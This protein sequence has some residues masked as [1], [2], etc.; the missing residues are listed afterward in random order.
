[1]VRRTHQQEG[2][3]PD[4]LGAALREGE[5]RDRSHQPVGGE[6]E[7]VA[8]VGERGDVAQAGVAVVVGLSEGREQLPQVDEVH[9]MDGQGARR[10]GSREGVRRRSSCFSKSSGAGRR[11]RVTYV[12]VRWRAPC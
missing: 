1:M 4:E 2:H 6:R 7:Q 10:E 3:G 8:R 12:R 5:G 11:R 9:L